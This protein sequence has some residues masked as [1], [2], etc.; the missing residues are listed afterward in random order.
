[1][2]G[3][4]RIFV[5]KET[6]EGAWLYGCALFACIIVAERGIEMNQTEKN[7]EFDKIKEIWSALALTDSAKRE[8]RET[9][10]VL[11]E[12]ELRARLRET[13]EAK[14]MME[15]MG[16]PPLSAMEGVRELMNA[17]ERGDCLTAAQ[18][19][20]AES[21]L[22]AVKRLKDYL[23]R[24]KALE[25]SLPW[26]EQ[27]LDE[28]EEIRETIHVRIRNGAVDDYASKLLHELRSGIVRIEEKMKEKAEA[29]IRSNKECMSDSFSVNRSGHLCVPVKKEYKFRVS[30]SV[31]DKSATGNTLFIEPT[32]VAKYSEELQLMRIDEENEE[33]RILY[34]LSAMLGEQG[35]TMEQNLKTMEKL[36]FCF[37][38]GKLSM[39]LGCAAPDIN[40]ER[41]IRL[42]AARHP[43]M[44]RAVCVPQDFSIGEPG[45]NVKQAPDVETKPVQGAG[46]RGVVITGPNTGG[47]TVAIK[48]VAVNCMMAQCGL[49]VCCEQADICMNSNYL[50][51][52]GDGQNLSENLSTFSAHITNVLDI[53]K[54]VN[55]E[56]LVIMDELGSGT[57]PAEG[58]GIAVAILEELRRSGCLFLV[59]T[60]YPEV[61]TYAEQAEGIIN[62]RMTF[63]KE[64]L[65]PLYK[66]EIGEAGES[67]AFYIAARLGMPETMLR[68]AERAAYG[69]RMGEASKLRGIP[70]PPCGDCVKGVE[71]P[72]NLDISEPE[73]TEK[74]RTAYQQDPRIQKK[75]N[76]GALTGQK[77]ELT[78]KFRRGDSVMVYPDKKIGIVCEPVNEKG[79]LRVQLRDRKI[80]I[81]HKRVRL[82][83]A[84]AELYPED[85]DF[86]I[87][88]DSVATRKLRHKMERKYVEGAELH[89]DQD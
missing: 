42:T 51:D 83:V 66:M 13:T 67:C 38:K 50:C 64:S 3:E 40:T 31:I 30:G 62:A 28:L 60:H 43:L 61:K 29:V 69:A 47:K 74:K 10:P 56:S 33:R 25:L 18:L 71:A 58:M 21:A 36:D 77:A 14:T 24:C 73:K 89:L 15:E 19:E 55:R 76:S 32:A 49:H 86:S 37:S 46:Y 4:R 63:D 81:S 68:T 6:I 5:V 34:T 45:G 70:K 41:R 54:K 9:E 1:M 59:T 39:E 8:I 78:E 26:Y 44:D 20:Q 88:F 17:A 85:Y 79:V 87:I 72:A 82:Q 11:S 57:D 22:T 75:K 48:T 84:A 52:I 16:T 12:V 53:L 80:W 2:D 35:E 23:N 7:L 65:R 27:N